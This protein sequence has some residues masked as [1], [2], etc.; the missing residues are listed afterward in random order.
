MSQ[1]PSCPAVVRG[2]TQF[3]FAHVQEITKFITGVRVMEELNQLKRK[4][5]EE[6]EEEEEVE[7]EEEE[8]EERTYL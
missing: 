1:K 2:Y 5:K 4:E 7:V 8:E 6:E 3:A